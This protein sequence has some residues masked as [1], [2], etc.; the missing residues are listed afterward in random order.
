MTSNRDGVVHVP[1]SPQAIPSGVVPKGRR[2]G[3]PAEPREPISR[4]AQRFAAA[5]LEVL[6][7]V[8][9]PTDASAV[10]GI[11]LPRYYLWEQRA[12]EGLVAACQP[13]GKG[14][15]VSSRCQILALEKEVGRL[16][17]ECARQQALVRA[18]QRTIGLAPPAM[19]K[20]VPKA[21]GKV[22]GKRTRKRRPAV[23]ALK[24]VAALRAASA[25]EDGG[26]LSGVPL[27]DVLQRS[28]VSNP[29]PLTMP[30]G[31]DTVGG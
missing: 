14:K 2:L 27:P 28:A 5:I 26:D 23:R 6:A 12:L 25:P 3:R 19:P 18:A 7:G 29:S 8:R 1:G 24:A 31:T 15:I 10:M 17:Q 30:V 13:R 22:A 16:K 21:G 9:T 11:S 4:E 20:S